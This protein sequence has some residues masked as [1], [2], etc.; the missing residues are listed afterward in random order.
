MRL[1]RKQTAP[2]GQDVLST[3]PRSCPIDVPALHAERD[4]LA[5]RV[6]SLW[7]QRKGLVRLLAAI[8]RN[9]GVSDSQWRRI[10][11]IL[12]AASLEP[13]GTYRME[14]DQQVKP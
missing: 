6:D 8:E 3:C 7:R 11:Q 12:K 2:L 1:F 5:G 4:R 14:V 9:G 13:S 10:D